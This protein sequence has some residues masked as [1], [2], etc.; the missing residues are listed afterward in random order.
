MDQDIPKLA[1]AQPDGN[2]AS[3]DLYASIAAGNF[4]EW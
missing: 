4:P 1:A 3:K 2:F